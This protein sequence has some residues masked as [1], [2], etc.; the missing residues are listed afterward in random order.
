[1]RAR[2][3]SIEPTS[4]DAWRLIGH[5][6][7]HRCHSD[8]D[9]RRVDHRARQLR[10]EIVWLPVQRGQ[11]VTVAMWLPLTA[12]VYMECTEPDCLARQ[13]YLTSDGSG[14]QP[15]S[16]LLPAF[17]QDG[18]L[19]Y[20]T[21]TTHPH[22]EYWAS[23]IDPEAAKWMT[24]ALAL[25]GGYLKADFIDYGP[26]ALAM[27]HTLWSIAGQHVTMLA[28]HEMAADEDGIIEVHPVDNKE[29]SVYPPLPPEIV[30]ER[31]RS[32]REAKG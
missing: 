9:W 17:I 12:S 26:E 11:D 8:P 13:I 24:T 2:S 29:T 6:L 20:F 4:Q 16:G 25:Y 15:A 23:S 18:A 27:G 19:A 30:A 5:Y 21:Y 31:E 22:G 32:Y 1:L 14:S 28:Q 7:H 3:Y 10:D